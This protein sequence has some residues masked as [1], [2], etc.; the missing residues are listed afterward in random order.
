MSGSNTT[1]AFAGTQFDSFYSF[2]YQYK[3]DKSSLKPTT[4]LSFNKPD[5]ISFNS[6]N[7]KAILGG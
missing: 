6:N 2:D 1:G 7:K 3:G 5:S 4:L